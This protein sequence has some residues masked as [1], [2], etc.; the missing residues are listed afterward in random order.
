MGM[1][2][3]IFRFSLC[4]VVVATFIRPALAS[5]A[6]ACASGINNDDSIAA[7][8]RLINSG[9]QNPVF[10][11]AAYEMRAG[12]LTTKN[13]D[14]ALMDCD[15]AISLNPNNGEA[16]GLRAFI[17]FIKG[18]FDRQVADFDNALQRNCAS[19]ACKI[20]YML[21][22]AGFL[23][24]GEFDRAYNDCS[25]DLEVSSLKPASYD[26]R[27]RALYFSNK[28]LDTALSD[29]GEAIR[30]EPNFAAYYLTRAQIRLAIGDTDDGLA[31]LNHAIQ[32]GLKNPAVYAY[33]G[34]VNER[35]GKE[36]D[37]RLAYEQSLTLPG[38]DF[39]SRTARDITRKRLSAFDAT[40]FGG[41]REA[42]RRVNKWYFAIMGIKQFE[43]PDATGGQ[44]RPTIGQVG[45][46]YSVADVGLCIYPVPRVVK[47]LLSRAKDNPDE[48]SVI[49]A[50][51]N[52]LI[53]QYCRL[54]DRIPNS[55]YDEDIGNSCTMHTGVLN[56]ERVYWAD[57]SG[58]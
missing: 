42:V 9:N 19:Y 11:S 26:C 58:G 12:Y 29:I 37:A 1:Q 53:M 45:Q 47:Q 34:M 54:A 18:D 22:G 25:R 33:F 15:L 6:T 44:S 21:R 51:V 3:R 32:L 16:F 14:L 5:D 57:C 56:R 38:N 17:W 27:A 36:K 43:Q 31:D 48:I 10:I 35:I 2:A 46:S 13:L 50:D 30:L 55:D 49:V 24:R 28:R 23:Q 40:F 20:G 7:C 8:T 52:Y 39:E 41:W 4:A